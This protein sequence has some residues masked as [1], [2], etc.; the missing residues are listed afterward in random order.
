MNIFRLIADM[1]HL[2]SFMILIQKIRG[3]RNCLGKI[4]LFF[5][6][7]MIVFIYNTNLNLIV[8]FLK[9]IRVII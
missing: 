9:K 8:F 5:N 2:I 7:I 1:L 3:T 6:I 4:N